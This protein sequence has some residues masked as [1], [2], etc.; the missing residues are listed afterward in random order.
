RRVAA[1][2]PPETAVL[3]LP[4]VKFPE[5]PPVE[6]MADYDHFDGYLHSDTLRWSYGVVRGRDNWQDGQRDLPLP[7]QLARAR[8]AGFGAVWLDRYGYRDDGRS[9]DAELTQCLGAPIAESED[10]RR[11]VYELRA[12]SC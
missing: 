8:D 2:L 6:R 7:A 3:Q 10:G 12:L 5:N 11:A 4:Y 9:L 1:L